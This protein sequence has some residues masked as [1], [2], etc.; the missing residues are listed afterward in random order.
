MTE[1]IHHS[2][3]LILDDKQE[4]EP[5]ALP[6]STGFQVM[7]M[8]QDIYRDR[9]PTDT[10]EQEQGTSTSCHASLDTNISIAH[11]KSSAD[12]SFAKTVDIGPRKQRKSRRTEKGVAD[13]EA[14][15]K[16]WTTEELK[17]L[18][19]W[20][21]SHGVN[22]NCLFH[23]MRNIPGRSVLD[24][25]NKIVEIRELV[26]LRQEIKIEAQKAEWLKEVIK[27]SKTSEIQDW[28]TAVKVV[29]NR[30]RR[31]IDHTDSALMHY[32]SYEV[33][34]RPASVDTRKYLPVTDS[35]YARGANRGQVVDCADYYR[36]LYSRL[37]GGTSSYQK[38]LD[39]AIILNILN[40]IQ[41]EVDDPK[42]EEK[43]RILAGTF[44][45]IQSGDLSHY[46]FKVTANN[47]DM[48][49]AQLNPLSLMHDMLKLND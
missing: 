16:E 21:N 44:R 35:P 9:E 2:S 37:S 13:N 46:D 40:E 34:C 49:S 39:A 7:L 17:A 29:Q 47:Q 19:D 11:D 12:E 22:D 28:S 33:K 20:I 14:A 38:P 27:P 31:I 5:S 15:G 45:D 43:R 18:H 41:Q 6:Q 24:I 36:F 26:R 42:H 4:N 10:A 25:R 1:N 23:A 32:L 30:K 48:L 8:A 3:E